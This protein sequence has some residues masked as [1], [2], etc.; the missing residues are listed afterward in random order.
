MLTEHQTIGEPHVNM[1]CNDT[2]DQTQRMR[3]IRIEYR[4]ITECIFAQ[5]FYCRID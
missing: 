3:R 4:R 1:G 2:L 5:C